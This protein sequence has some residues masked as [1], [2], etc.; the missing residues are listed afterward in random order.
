[1]FIIHILFQH[2]LINMVHINVLNKYLVKMCC[3]VKINMALENILDLELENI[4]NYVFKKKMGTHIDLIH[5]LA[6]KVND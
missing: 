3:T 6:D 5:Y 2:E 4:K 1:M